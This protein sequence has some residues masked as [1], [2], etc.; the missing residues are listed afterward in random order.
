MHYYTKITIPE[1]GTIYDIT[2]FNVSLILYLI[3]YLKMMS[4]FVFICFQDV[5]NYVSLIYPFVLL[6]VGLFI[7]FVMLKNNCLTYALLTYFIVDL[8][9]KYDLIAF[10]LCIKIFN[11][12]YYLNEMSFAFISLFVMY[13]L[14]ELKYNITVLF[15]IN[16]IVDYISRYSIRKISN[17]IHNKIFYKYDDECGLKYIVNLL[18][19]KYKIMNVEKYQSDLNDSYI[20]NENVEIKNI[21]E[22][23]IIECINTE[24]ICLFVFSFIYGFFI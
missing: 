4:I 18:F 6:C 3:L 16:F 20:K 2:N 14:Y 23:L 1:I 13:V 15:L 24:M 9:C 12:A 21:D 10:Y 19:Y 22:Y 8:F 11:Y 5:N 7:K 17:E